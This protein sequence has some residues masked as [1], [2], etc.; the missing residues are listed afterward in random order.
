MFGEGGGGSC[1]VSL[2]EIIVHTF[3]VNV[4]TWRWRTEKREGNLPKVFKGFICNLFRNIFILFYYCYFCFWNETS[5][6][7]LSPL[8]PLTSFVSLVPFLLNSLAVLQ[9]YFTVKSRPHSIGHS[10]IT[11]ANTRILMNSGID[12]VEQ[13]G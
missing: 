7:F 5:K 11:A 13:W 6:I 3:L 9:L 8:P 2:L 1:F 4:L 12:F 10:R